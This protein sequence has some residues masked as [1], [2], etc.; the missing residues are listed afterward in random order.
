MRI[1]TDIDCR[2]ILRHPVGEHT[3]TENPKAEGVLKAR[4]YMREKG[5]ESLDIPYDELYSECAEE[6]I[7][8]L[9]EAGSKT[10]MLAVAKYARRVA[11]SSSSPDKVRLMFDS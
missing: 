11:K 7:E 10:A 9:D 8:Y 6:H 2:R 1:T 4:N 5:K 3:D